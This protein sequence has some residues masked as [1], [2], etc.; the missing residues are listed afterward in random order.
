MEDTYSSPYCQ[1]IIFTFNFVILLP[2]FR[3]CPQYGQ[4]I[5]CGLNNKPFPL[6]E[7][8]AAH[9]R[10]FTYVQDIVDGLEKLIEHK[11]ACDGEIS[12]WHDLMG[13]YP[14]FVPPFAEPRADLTAAIKQA[15]LDYKN[16]N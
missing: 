1:V 5:D 2:P 16:T 14:W 15:L 6:Y 3:S 8:S 11:D 13:A 9:L 12:V 10:S 7:G 4:Q